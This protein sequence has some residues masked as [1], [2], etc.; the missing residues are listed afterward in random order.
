MAVESVVRDV[1]NIAQRKTSDRHR[2]R[3]PRR[4]ALMAGLLAMAALSL[5]VAFGFPPAPY[6]TLYGMVRDQ[7]GQTITAEGAELVLLKD[8]VEIG[9]TP[10]NGAFRLDQNYE[11]KVR[12]DQNRSATEIYT[13]RAITSGGAFS[14]VVAMNG[15]L[16]YPIEVSG[17]LTA[18]K[19]GERVRLDLNLGED[20]DLDGL[21]DIWEQWQL[22][23]AGYSPD[24][25]G[26]WPI[27][28][29]DRDGDMDGDGQSNYLEYR[30]GTFA[31]DATETLELAIVETL[32][33]QVR[34][35][36]FA[37]TGKTYTIER[38]TDLKSWTRVAFAVETPQAPAFFQL[39]VASD[40]VSSADEFEEL[41]GQ[42]FT[43]PREVT[44]PAA[45]TNSFALLAV[46]ASPPASE[47]YSATDVGIL[48]ARATPIP[49]AREFYQLTVR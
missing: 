29:I 18:G 10:I 32:E 1:D 7:V 15:A 9:R 3:L 36:F 16:F 42:A 4:A 38:S 20:S 11:L 31:G 24:G 33:D 35:E 40:S 5:P 49:G 12:I 19:G 41:T 2:I 14:L 28:L 46:S 44:T 34:F 22:F 6:Y 48:S 27:N 26:N 39:A 13:D 17:N 8:G 45:R 47:I 23:Q 25:S 21:P 37:I 43:D 30:A